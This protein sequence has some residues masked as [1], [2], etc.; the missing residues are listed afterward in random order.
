MQ[1]PPS[2]TMFRLER[3]RLPLLE[4]V[5]VCAASLLLLPKFAVV[6]FVNETLWGQIEPAGM[7][8]V[9]LQ[10]VAVAAMVCAALLWLARF[11]RWRSF[12]LAMAVTG[13]LLLVLMMD[14]RAR[15]LWLKPTDW[16]LVSYGVTHF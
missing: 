6:H 2:A 3:M 14:A 7:V 4:T 11:G 13:F 15:E 9:A 1:L 16:N 5:V 10:D 12:Q 8:L